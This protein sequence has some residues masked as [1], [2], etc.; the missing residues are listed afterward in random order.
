ML[1]LVDWPIQRK[2]GFLVGVGALV[3]L[4]L[5]CISFAV[6]DIRMI[7]IAKVKQ[8]R[9]LVDIIGFNA[10]PSLEFEDPDSAAKILSSLRLQPSIEMGA[11][12]NAEGELL[13]TYPNRLEVDEEVEK[14]C[15]PLKAQFTDDGFLVI[16][17]EI[18]RDGDKVGTIYL[19][20]NLKEIARELREVALIALAVLTVSLA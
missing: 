12:Y 10:T 3:A 15:R 2:L 8:V 20:S 14:Y 18:I 4:L 11:L 7:R 19:R 1:R 5:T 17:R 16:A 13:A 9:T 6:H